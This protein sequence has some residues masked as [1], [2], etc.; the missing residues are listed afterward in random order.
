MLS[1][2]ALQGIRFLWTTMVLTY[3]K[4]VCRSHHFS[5]KWEVTQVSLTLSHSCSWCS[6]SLFLFDGDTDFLINLI[7]VVPKTQGWHCLCQKL[8]WLNRSSGSLVSKEQIYFL[9]W[10][11]PWCKGQGWDPLKRSNH[12]EGLNLAKQH[13]QRNGMK[14]FGQQP[15][16]ISPGCF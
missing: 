1:R 14:I 2:T 13:R 11:C 7:V 10:K 3:P 15:A 8:A 16:T 6:P 12:L 5:H 9:H 4:T